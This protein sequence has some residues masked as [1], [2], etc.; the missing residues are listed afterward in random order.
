MSLNDLEI[1][2]K[3]H[4]FDE[5]AFTEVPILMHRDEAQQRTLELVEELRSEII[6]LKTNC[7]ILRGENDV[8]HSAIELVLET[9]HKIV[10]DQANPQQRAWFMQGWSQAFFQMRRIKEALDKVRKM[11]QSEI[12]TALELRDNA[13]LAAKI[14]VP[15]GKT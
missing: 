4:K 11:S 10:V 1:N 13:A 7:D 15:N 3:R 5:A 9:E 8:L 6:T 14:Q 2:D 12:D